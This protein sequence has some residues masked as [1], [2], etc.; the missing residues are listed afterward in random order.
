MK[1]S[2]I[3]VC[4]NSVATLQDT[5]DSVA[6]QDYPLIEHIVI[7]GASTDGTLELLKRNQSQLS[8]WVSEPDL[9]MYDAMN[10][11]IA[12]ASGEVIAFLNADDVYTNSAAI[13]MLMHALI[14]EDTDA[15]FADLVMVRANEPKRVVRYY[16][17]SFFHP[18]KF[19]WGWMPAHPTVFLKKSVYTAVGPYALDYRIAADYEMLIRIFYVYRASYTY[20][21]K[22]LVRMRLG[23]ASTATWQSNW[24]LN[25]EIIRAC[26]THGI[27]TNWLMLL[28][29]VPRKVWGATGQR[30]LGTKTGA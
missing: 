13:S 16:D 23:G 18:G 17:S 11:G 3:T 15:V 30:W 4:F 20:L 21:A 25:Q 14:K 1:V 24:I 6:L 7:D 10:K 27:Y 29:K 19:R 2:I 26:K 12:R 28:L 8:Q 5:I 22:P 9:G